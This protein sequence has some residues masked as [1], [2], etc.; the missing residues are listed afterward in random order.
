MSVHHNQDYAEVEELADNQDNCND[1]VK[2]DQFS[3][4]YHYVGKQ[5][6]YLKAAIYIIKRQTHYQYD[7]IDCQIV[8]QVF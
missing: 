6:L 3:A 8:I 7:L 5:A 2:F 4:T 1:Y